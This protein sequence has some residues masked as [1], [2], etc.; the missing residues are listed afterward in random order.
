M[1]H[2]TVTKKPFTIPGPGVSRK[3]IQ[4]PNSF[5]QQNELKPPHH[6]VT[7]GNEDVQQLEV[8]EPSLFHILFIEFMHGLI[9]FLCCSQLLAITSL[10]LQF[11][12]IA[13]ACIGILL[14]AVTGGFGSPLVVLC[15]IIAGTLP[16]S[17]ILLF[18]PQIWSAVCII[19]IL[20]Y[21]PFYEQ[22]NLVVP[23]TF[24][25]V[26]VSRYV[27][28]LFVY[29][30]ICMIIFC[31]PYAFVQRTLTTYGIGIRALYYLMIAFFLCCFSVDPVITLFDPLL[32]L[33]Y[34]GLPL[35]YAF[36]DC[37]SLFF[38]FLI[39]LLLYALYRPFTKDGYHKL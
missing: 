32:T 18:I 5:I 36:V 13:M 25:G 28:S 14:G 34:L 2:K 8:I 3:I 12:F 27:V 21:T 37:A 20:W 35:S 17:Y 4:R 19:T 26:I 23:L 22:P 39:A 29:P 24:T 10:A 1:S 11:R 6:I 30:I 33:C 31:N 38:A 16:V 9:Y 7:I 15:M